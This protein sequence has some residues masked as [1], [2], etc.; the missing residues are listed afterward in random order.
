[1]YSGYFFTFT[2]VTEYWAFMSR[3]IYL[4]RFAPFPKNTFNILYNI[5][6]DKNYFILTTNADHLFQ[7]A[8]FDKNKLFYMQGD[9]GLLQFKKP[10]HF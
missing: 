1:M 10:C 7:R 8:N 6:K 9:M 3:N 5:F 2:K 4:N